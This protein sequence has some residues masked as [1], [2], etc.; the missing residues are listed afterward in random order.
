[1]GFGRVLKKIG[2]GAVSVAKWAPK[3]VGA[4]GKAFLAASPAGSIGMKALST[5]KTAGA[6]W[7]TLKAVEQG[8]AVVPISQ[9][10]QVAKS[11]EQG[12]FRPRIALQTVP[13]VKSSGAQR[14]EQLKTQAAL[15]ERVNRAANEAGADIVKGL[16]ADWEKA[17]RPGTWVDYLGQSLGVK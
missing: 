13:L 4:A 16:R 10:A 15:K 5:L 6:H 3:G 11:Q 2:R 9:L 14:V 8:K 1:M 7:K 12:T 17:G